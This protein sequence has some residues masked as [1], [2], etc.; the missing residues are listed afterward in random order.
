MHTLFQAITC[1]HGKISEFTTKFMGFYNKRS[2]KIVNI[3]RVKLL[4]NSYNI[5]ITMYKQL[6]LR[7]INPEEIFFCPGHCFEVYHLKVHIFFLA[8]FLTINPEVIFFTMGIALRKFFESSY[9]I[10]DQLAGYKRSDKD[11]N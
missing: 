6:S 7:T 4:Q 5:N 1:K 8:M 11:S 3:T 10:Y 2:I 9:I